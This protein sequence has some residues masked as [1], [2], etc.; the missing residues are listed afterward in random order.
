M[1]SLILK[2]GLAINLLLVLSYVLFQLGRIGFEKARWN[3][4]YLTLNRVAQWL[5]GAAVISPVLFLAVPRAS[6]PDVKF[7]VRA[8]IA[9]TLSLKQTKMKRA[10][11]PLQVS[12]AIA[13]VKESEVLP[14]IDLESGILIALV[15]S[16][17]VAFTRLFKNLL[18]LQTVLKNSILVRSI[19]RVRILVSDE[20][21]IPF[22]TLVGRGASVVLP[23]KVLGRPQDM[24]L[25]LR[26]EI[27]HH[28]NGDTVWVLV[29]E[30]LCCL[31]ALNP[32]VYLWKK[33]FAEIQEFACDEKLIS[34]VGVSMREYGQCLINIAESARGLG[35]AQVGTTCMGAGPRG[36]RELKSFLRRRIE[37]FHNHKN[38]QRKNLLGV[39]FGTI[40]FIITAGAAYGAQKSLRGEAK[41]K[42]NQGVALFDAEI[43]KTTEGILKKYVAK[44]KAKGGFVLVAD[45]RTGRVLAVANQ[46]TGASKKSK[47]WALSYEMQPASAMKGVIAASAISRGLTN[48]D[49]KW[50]CENGKFTMGGHVYKDWKGFGQLTTTDAIA[51]SSNICG[52]KIGTKLGAK[53]L[54]ES[55]KEFGFGPHGVTE[56]FPEAVPGRFPASSEMPEAEY[57][58]MV[59]VGYTNFPGFHVTPLEILQAYGAIA[60]GGRLMRP[61][62]FSMPAAPGV[63]LRQVV[64]HEASEKMKSILVKVVKSGTGQK[65]QSELYSTAGKTSTAHGIQKEFPET[66]AREEG[67]AG[68]VGFAPVEN[69]RLVVYVGMIDPT[70]S[71]DGN[72]H[73]NEHAAPVFR[74]VIETVLGKMNVAPDLKTVL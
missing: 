68:F 70:N 67:I 14:L 49:E 47:A 72:P 66:S 19:G 22:S 54:E 21:R 37:V 57:I 30:I 55:L 31:F 13:Q 53:G 73:G 64:S 8:P 34:Q 29:M 16:L 17:L 32:F 69:P 40:A 74:E 25:I 9:D 33:L 63:M 15:A 59:S 39:T 41:T 62:D 23:S 36:S 44:F 71:P 18:Q 20:I 12:Q 24:A 51:N 56:D 26:H 52:I 11:P 58:P 10:A 45:P 60:N 38:P 42:P 27:H 46:A 43:Q 50:D 5:V 35:S 3:T 7:E 28:R 48:A 65:A 1:I 61:L 6:I 4:S 2:L